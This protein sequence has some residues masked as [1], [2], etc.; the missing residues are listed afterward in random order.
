MQNKF[1]GMYF[2]VFDGH[3]GWQVANACSK[4]LHLYID[5]Q[6]TSNDMS[7]DKVKQAI[8]KGFEKM[9]NEL[10][11]IAKAGYENG[12]PQAA[13]A[14][15]CALVAIV[16]NN[17]LYVANAGDSKGVLLRQKCNKLEMVKISKTFSANK[18]Y[19]QDRLKRLFPKE[20][21]IIH[22]RSKTA[23]YVK[24]G[25]MPTRS[26]GDFRLKYREF[27]F[28]EFGRD[29]GFRKSIPFFTGP[30]VSSEP[31]IQVFDLTPSDRYLV[32][33]SDGLWDEISRKQ[34]AEIAT[35]AQE[36][37]YSKNE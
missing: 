33:A 4:K 1:K 34:A 30:Y 3:V 13:Y 17:K 29:H 27:N 21:D 11:Q 23:C 10:L 16:H 19:E 32:L 20:R 18:K 36:E 9:E 6:L 25:L 35:E 24:G 5:E 8:T 22:C 12:Y 14:G 26:L 28:H 7:D 31:D 15:A 37:A 2:A